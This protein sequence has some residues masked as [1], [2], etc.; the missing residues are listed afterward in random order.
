DYRGETYYFCHPNC[1]RKFSSDPQ[2]YLNSPPQLAA[3]HGAMPQPIVQLSGQSKSPPVTAAQSPRV[4]TP[5]PANVEYT[6]PMDPEVVQIGPGAC[7]KCGMALEPATLAAP[8]TKTEYVCPMHPEI[9]QDEPGSCPICGMA[10]EPRVITL[11]EE[12]NP[13]LKDM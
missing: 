6:C 4:E 11:E 10:L 2:T 7:P 3:M 13:E 12:E 9:A 1:L 8:M 5:A